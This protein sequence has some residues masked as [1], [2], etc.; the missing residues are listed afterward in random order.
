METKRGARDAAQTGWDVVQRVFAISEG[1]ELPLPPAAPAN[2]PAAVALGR[3]GG[4]KGGM[5]RAANL[6]PE[7]R[8]QIAEKAAAARWLKK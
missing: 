8:K 2:N 5:Q 4:T 7:R 6:T 1:R 3:L